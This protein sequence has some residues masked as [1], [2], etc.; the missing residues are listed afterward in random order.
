MTDKR[1]CPEDPPAANC[2]RETRE[3]DEADERRRDRML[4][5]EAAQNQQ[6]QPTVLDSLRRGCK[7]RRRHLTTY[8]C[9]ETADDQEQNQQ[10]RARRPYHGSARDES[11]RYP[12][13]STSAYRSPAGVTPA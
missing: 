5:D 12:L 8:P 11:Q 9:R 2:M 4:S 3:Q 13:P 7:R 6:P 1:G 10:R